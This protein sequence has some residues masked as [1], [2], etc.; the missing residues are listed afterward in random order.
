MAK[1]GTFDK[2][3]IGS[4]S[5]MFFGERKQSKDGMFFGS[6]GAPDPTSINDDSDESIKEADGSLA[7]RAS[8]VFSG[9]FLEGA[10]RAAKKGLQGADDF[11]QK[12]GRTGVKLLHKG[13]DKLEGSSDNERLALLGAGALGTGYVGVKAAKGVG[14]AVKKTVAKTKAPAGLWSRIGRAAKMIRGR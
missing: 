7:E 4:K 10:G 8:S 11:V 14:G 1:P 2:D 5:G 9:D 12:A 6:T 13:L 3:R